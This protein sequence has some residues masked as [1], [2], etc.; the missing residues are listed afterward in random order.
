MAR[1]QNLSEGYAKWSAFDANAALLEL[2]NEDKTA[3]GNAVRCSSRPES[4]MLMAEGYKKE[5]EE[6]ELDEEIALKAGSL[7]QSVAQRMKDAAGKKLE[8]NELLRKGKLDDAASAYKS[9]L[10]ALE[11]CQMASV[12]MADSVA[13]KASALR[14]DLHRLGRGWNMV[15]GEYVND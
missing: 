11:L 10:E 14:A 12:L 15:P 6:F 1:A 4:A 13:A 2:D 8:G 9:G 5:R 3:E 7:K